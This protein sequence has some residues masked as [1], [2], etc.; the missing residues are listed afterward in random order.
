MRHGVIQGKDAITGTVKVIVPA[1]KSLDH[2]GIKVELI[3]QIGMSQGPY[4]RCVDCREFL[5]P[6]SSGPSVLF[7]F[8]LLYPPPACGPP[9]SMCGV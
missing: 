4:S 9:F 8:A 1:G 7:I 5:V 6:R 3:G 2:T